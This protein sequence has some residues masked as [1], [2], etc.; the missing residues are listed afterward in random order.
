MKNQIIF[1]QK[2]EQYYIIEIV[3]AHSNLT[4]AQKELKGLVFQT[5]SLVDRI[6]KKRSN[7]TKY[8]DKLHNTV[9]NFPSRQTCYKHKR[10]YIFVKDYLTFLDCDYPYNKII[11]CAESFKKILNDPETLQDKDLAKFFKN[12]SNA[13]KVSINSN[14][15]EILLQSPEEV[16]DINVRMEIMNISNTKT[17]KPKKGGKLK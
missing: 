6:T 12:Y 16:A 10:Y 14:I 1:Q 13:K 4:L 7:I 3:K 15:E 9:P 11:D 5:G 8:L 2:K 17:T